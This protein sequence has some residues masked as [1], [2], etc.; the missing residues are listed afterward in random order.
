MIAKTGFSPP[1]ADVSRLPL[2]AAPE[3]QDLGAV[4]RSRRK[5]PSKAPPQPD[6]QDLAFAVFA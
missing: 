3:N 1:T 6:S 2:P 4:K 5:S